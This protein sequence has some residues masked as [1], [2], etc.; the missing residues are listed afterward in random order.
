MFSSCW[1]YD[2]YY[3]L[4]LLVNSWKVSLKLSKN[5][6]RVINGSDFFFIL[7]LFSNVNLI[8]PSVFS[9]LIVK[10][11]L[12][13]LSLTTLRMIYIKTSHL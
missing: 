11:V 7:S 3:Y 2:Y 5:L 12:F 13:S 4:H 8:R 6:T 9:T 1:Y 10:P